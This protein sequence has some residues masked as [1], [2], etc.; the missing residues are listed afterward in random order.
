MTTLAIYPLDVKQFLVETLRLPPIAKAAYLMIILDY[1]GRGEPPPDNDVIL[2]QI[3][4]TNNQNILDAIRPLF[5][6]RDGFWRHAAIDAE[7]ERVAK[8]QAN[9]V[10]ASAA[11]AAKK[12]GKPVAAKI[13]G[14]KVD[15]AVFVPPFEAFQGEMT[16]GAQASPMAK[17]VAPIETP[18]AARAAPPPPSEKGPMP[19]T[20][21]MMTIGS[22]PPTPAVADM[23]PIP[24]DF[25]L[26]GEDVVQLTADGFSM[27][28]IADMLD[29]FRDYNFKHGTLS[30]DWNAK[31]WRYVDQKLSE[32]TKAG[33]VKA[34][35]RVEVSRRAP[36][37]PS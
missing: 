4:G 30:D 20:D 34:K 18:P 12:T 8:V 33:I 31:F 25:A 21:V 27:D 15:N 23:A 2:N 24:D 1:C 11:A 19:T 6:V 14:F 17:F 37:P 16:R 29:Y 32:R 7:I 26:T 28:E 3:T 10:R 5:E 35:P 9:A 36:P 13:D 22:V